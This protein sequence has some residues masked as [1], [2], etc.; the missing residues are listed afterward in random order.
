MMNLE[1]IK[2]LSEVS[3]FLNGSR[4]YLRLP[5]ARMNGMRGYARRCIDSIIGSSAKV[6][7]D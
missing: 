3:D 2:T 5:V 6:S 4:S 7:E 1:N